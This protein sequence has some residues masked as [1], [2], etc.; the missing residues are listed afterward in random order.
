[1]PSHLAEKMKAPSVVA[2]RYDLVI[3]PSNLWLTIHESIGHATEFDR[4]IGYEAAYAGTSFATP[5]KLGTLAYGS[6]IMNVTG[7]RTVPHGLATIGYD[8]DGVAGQSWDLI[9]DGTLV[10]YQLDRVF[11]LRLG[12]DR[13][14][15]CALADSPAHIP[16]Q[17]MA[18]VSPATGPVG[19]V[20]RRP[21]RR[22]RERHLRRRRQVVVDRHAAVQ[23]P[24]HRPAVL[25]D[26]GRRAGRPGA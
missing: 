1:M 14:N 23:L 4:A 24:V 21:D 7:D 18:N 3:D 11:A 17:R 12:L 25:Q 10:G 13:S 19:R 16:I 2:G 9:K 15:G 6:S 20:D 22:R 8:D 26:R 5:D